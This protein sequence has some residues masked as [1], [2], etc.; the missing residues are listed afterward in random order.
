MGMPSYNQVYRHSTFVSET[1]AIGSEMSGGV[2]NIT[3]DNCIFGTEGSDFDGIHLK[4]MRGRGGSIHGIR[5]KNS[6]FHSE[7]SV[8]QPMPISAS[9]FYSGNP[10]P[11]NTSA[12]PHV[13]DVAVSNV[14]IHLLPQSKS[15][16]E[17]NH[18]GSKSTQHR[19]TD[20]KEDL[21]R[22]GA[23]RGPSYPKTSFQ[24]IGLEE[25]IMH[26]VSFNGMHVVGGVSHGWYCEHT[27]GFSF[28]DVS[29]MPDEAS[30]CLN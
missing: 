29:P 27:K 20:S 17:P 22:F 18:N 21:E 8:K 30:G 5:I 1:F 2:Y 4:T 7:S 19:S 13:Y 16:Q 14:T 3:V 23:E 26:D 6:I 11:T 28:K 15:E 25:S 10:A 24:F 9:L 12:T